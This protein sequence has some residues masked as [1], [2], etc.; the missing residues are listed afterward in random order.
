MRPMSGS[1]DKSQS[2]LE[3]RHQFS[4]D[5]LCMSGRHALAINIAKLP[6]LLRKPD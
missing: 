4:V 5:R 1:R 6:H 2:P 3:K